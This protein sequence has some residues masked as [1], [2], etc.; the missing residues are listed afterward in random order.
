VELKL[1]RCSYG[2]IVQPLT[3]LTTT[4][5]TAFVRVSGF[6]VDRQLRSGWFETARPKIRA[7][8]RN[9]FNPLLARSDQC[10]RLLYGLVTFKSPAVAMVTRENKQRERDIDGDAASRCTVETGVECVAVR[11][12]DFLHYSSQEFGPPGDELHN[13]SVCGPCCLPGACACPSI[14]F[15][16]CFNA[17]RQIAQATEFCMV[18]PNIC[19]E[20]MP[21]FWHLEF[22]GGVYIFGQYV[23]RCFEGI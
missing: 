5:T 11:R 2:P 12:V 17:G 21:L 1:S 20:L 23:H 6:A 19:G 10:G 15:H 7:I 8:S 16:E 14:L 13:L 22:G 4:S 18:V 3:I 9:V